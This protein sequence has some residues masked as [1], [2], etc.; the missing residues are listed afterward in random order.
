VG[1]FP[2]VESDIGPGHGV[3][4]NTHQNENS[5]LSLRW[6][7][8]GSGRMSGQRIGPKRGALRGSTTWLGRSSSGD[9]SHRVSAV[10]LVASILG[11]AAFLGAPIVPAALHPSTVPATCA[12]PSDCGIGPAVTN[13]TAPLHG[14]VKSCSSASS[15]DF[16]FN[17]SG[18]L[19]WANASPPS[20]SL[21]LPGEALTSTGLSY[22][23]YT[24]SLIGTYTYWTVGHFVGTDVNTGKVVYG[25]TNANY[26][27]T[28]Y[29]HSGRG[30]GCTY[31][32]TTD[33][34]TIVVNFTQAEQTTTSATCAPS[35]IAPGS[36]SV[37]TATVN[38]TVNA[39]TVP[40]GNV[41]FTGSF[42]S[43]AEF[44]NG[45]VC[46]L[47]SGS[48]SVLYTAP[49]EQLGTV[50]V[51]ATFAGTPSFYI[52]AGR[53]SIYVS[54][55][56]GGG[57]SAFSAVWFTE[58]GL[59]NGTA[60]S[61]TLGGLT[62]DSTNSS[63]QFELQNGTYPYSVGAVPGYFLSPKAG[64]VT[65][66]GTDTALNVTFGSVAYPLTF[67]ATG[68]PAGKWW[69][70]S[71]DGT[72]RRTSASSLTLNETN[73]THS[74]L[75]RGPAG[76][77]VSGVAPGAEVTVSGAPVV[78]TFSFV[79]QPTFAVVF[80]E[81]GL[82]R[83]T[84]WCVDLEGIACAA[85]PVL[86]FVNLTPATY[87]YA[88]LP[89]TGQVISAKLGSSFINL[90][91]NLTLSNHTLRIQLHY[92]FPYQ[93]SFVESGLPSGTNWSV[94]V[95]GI[96]HVSN[97]STITFALGNGTHYYRIGAIIGYTHSGSPTAARVV[98]GPAVVTVTF[99]P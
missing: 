30:G 17:A 70:V 20:M 79:K 60:W 92:T 75:I 90:S 40:T 33:N 68:L 29:G 9:N 5:I 31:T 61:V 82:P 10:I 16:V 84:T 38:D 15:C 19:G 52:S 51:V 2:S 59:A 3:L 13:T 96:T 74:Y 99:R 65:V 45:G 11:S 95:A 87:P 64:N 57:G 39:S 86:R 93:V 81:K 34:G 36:S 1:T 55:T 28:C 58:N 91:G 7:L 94:S 62:L 44:S 25:W 47:A 73:G 4:L 77:Q 56:G 88:V 41:S 76:F 48:C 6:S 69:G 21:R 46:V 23:T 54:S 26:T 66:N 67:N 24:A 8:S 97:N 83:N 63:I 71:V 22:S 98:G 43:T 18:V 72:L 27:I 85:V 50:G 32:Y 35:T 80:A 37:C 53:T 78:V 49:D 42:G 14:V 89:M 12:A